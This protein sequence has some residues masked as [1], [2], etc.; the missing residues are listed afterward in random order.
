MFS[1]YQLHIF[2]LSLDQKLLFSSAACFLND[3]LFLIPSSLTFRIVQDPI[4]ATVIVYLEVEYWPDSE[5]CF[6]TSPPHAPTCLFHWGL[7]TVKKEKGTMWKDGCLNGSGGLWKLL[8][9]LEL[10]S[11]RLQISG[12]S[13]ISTDVIWKNSHWLRHFALY[14]VKEFCWA[15]KNVPVQSQHGN[16]HLALIKHNLIL[17]VC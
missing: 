15:G 3:R 14:S 10:Q 13:Q 9:F 12:R 8:V 17:I 2:C 4:V 7:A 11:G 16:P 5:S 1:N 6:P